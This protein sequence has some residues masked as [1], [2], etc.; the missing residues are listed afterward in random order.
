M[1]K[2]ESLYPQMRFGKGN[3]SDRFR[4]FQRFTRLT[5]QRNKQHQSDCKASKFDQCY[6]QRGHRRYEKRDW[7]FFKRTV[8]NSFLASKQDFR[9]W[10]K[11]MAITKIHP[12]KSTLHLA[13]DYI[14]N[15]DKTDEQLLDSTHKC[16]QSNKK[17]YHKIR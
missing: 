2:Y 10:L 8:A 3:L 13:I 16:Y 6:L 5:F 4:A 1:Q 15:G 9:R 12:I 11:F 14:V 7:T 17:N